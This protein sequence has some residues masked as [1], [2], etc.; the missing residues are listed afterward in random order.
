ML[1]DEYVV[2]EVGAVVPDWLAVVLLFV[3]FLGSVYVVLPGVVLGVISSGTS[4]MTWPAIVCTA[5][6]MF[7]FIKPVADV[8]RPEVLPPIGPEALPTVISPAYELGLSFTSGAFPSGHALVATVFWGLVVIDTR[9]LSMR[10]RAFVA[11]TIVSSVGLS[12]VALSVHYPGD[13]LGGVA[14]GLGILSVAL[15][16]R[17]QF[18]EP[19]RPLLVLAAVPSTGAIVTGRVTDGVLLLVAILVMALAHWSMKQTSG[20]PVGVLKS[21]ARRWNR[22]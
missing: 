6:G 15:A 2:E 7:V 21:Q 3:G 8:S 13:I 12:R 18:V 4:R 16:I 14:L 9:V 1:F 20:D 11:A 10:I 5:Y 19:F 17:N 22:L